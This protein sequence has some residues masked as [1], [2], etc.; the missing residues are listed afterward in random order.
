LQ[1]KIIAM[2]Y[3]TFMKRETPTIEGLII[4]F[5]NILETNIKGITPNGYLNRLLLTKTNKQFVECFGK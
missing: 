2:V 4:E 5:W 1:A 3:V